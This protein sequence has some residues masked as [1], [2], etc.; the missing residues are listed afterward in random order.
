[1]GVEALLRWKNP[2]LGSVS[3]VEFIPIAEETGLIVPLG[4]WVLREA[5]RLGK[6]WHVATGRPLRVA[7]NI[8]PRQVRESGFEG[9]VRRIL[10]EYD[11]PPDLL[12]LELTEG[13]VIQNDETIDAFVSDL[14]SLGVR[15]ALDDFGTGYSSL[16]YLTRLQIDVL[17]IDRSFVRA[18]GT[19][20]NESITLAVLAL[21]RTL[22]I[23]VVAEGVETEAQLEF[24]EQ[25][26]PVE[27]QGYYFA[28]PMP[29]GELIV[30]QATFQKEHGH[31][32]RPAPPVTALVDDGSAQ[33]GKTRQ[34]QPP[35][36]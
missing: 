14:Q 27:V 21:A 31:R 26:G 16:N 13:V 25:Q 6:E 33:R 20:R 9:K 34:S 10:E 11:F 30:W 3:P 12:E 18:L 29:A 1:V 7:V 36:S 17:K 35:T 5:C 22:S 15:I 2:G 28:R 8:S 4:E 19:P 24:F 32:G 23:D